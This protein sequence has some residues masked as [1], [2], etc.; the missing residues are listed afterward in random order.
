MRR[1]AF[2]SVFH[3]SEKE[4][5][6]Q[7]QDPA[8]LRPDFP[9]HVPRTQPPECYD[10]KLEDA[11]A[12]DPLLSIPFVLRMTTYKGNCTDIEPAITGMLSASP[13]MVL[14]GTHPVIDIVAS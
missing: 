1:S 7:H 11:L 3:H 12:A 10:G 8:S 13:G 5:L 4:D 6:A 9:L 14:I 2:P